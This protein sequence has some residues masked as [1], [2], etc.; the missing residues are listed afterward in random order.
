MDQQDE[1]PHQ[2]AVRIDSRGGEALLDLVPAVPPGHG[3]REQAHEVRIEAERLADIADGAARPIGDEGRRQR[4]PVPAVAPVDVLD[5]LLAPLVLEVDVDVRRLVALLGDEALE[6]E[7]HPRRVHLG[8]AEAVADRRI[9][10]GAAPLAEDVLAAGETDDVVDGEEEV[11]VAQF[12]NEFQLLLDEFPD[13]RRHPGRPALARP[14]F[15]ELAQMRRRRQHR[16]HQFAGIL[17]AQF[18]QAERAAIR[19]RHGLR[20]HLARIDRAELIE[21]FQV[22]LAVL[23]DLSAEFMYRAL[24]P[25]GGQHVLQRLALRGVHDGTVAGDDRQIETHREIEDAHRLRDVVALGEE[26]EAKPKIR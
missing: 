14:G 11:L 7:M 2:M 18:V 17:V 9:G 21:R 4:R 25:D 1:L 5:D 8:D 20:E 3:L 15:G 12:G 22:A 19:Q 6:Q 24:L 10:G 13:L 23:I 26:F 16:R